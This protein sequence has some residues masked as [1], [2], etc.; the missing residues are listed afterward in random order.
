ML[1]S[2]YDLQ[3]GRYLCTGLN[4]KNQEELVNALADY[5][6]SDNEDPTCIIPSTPEDVCMFGFEIIEHEEELE[7]DY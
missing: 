7:E 1:Y 2:A 5:I 4:S 3:C 6:N